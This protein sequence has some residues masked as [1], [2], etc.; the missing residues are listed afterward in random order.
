[1]CSMWF[2][3]SNILILL[4]DF[5]K[6]SLSILQSRPVV[7]TANSVECMIWPI[8]ASCSSILRCVC[9]GTQDRRWRGYQATTWGGTAV[10]L[11]CP[12]RNTDYGIEW[13]SGTSS[14]VWFLMYVVQRKYWDLEILTGLHVPV[15]LNAACLFAYTSMRPSLSSER[16][17][18]F[19]SYS[20][21]KGLSIIGR[22]SVTMEN[23]AQ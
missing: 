17:D 23:L 4:V 5:F 1:M 18:R 13:S 12:Q 11:S 10:S 20:F 15:P 3:A 22:C 6:F 8:P 9:Q 7:T 2:T 21:F 14:A 19:Y 16:L